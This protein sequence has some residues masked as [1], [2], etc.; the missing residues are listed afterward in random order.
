MVG[1]V[2]RRV[3][4]AILRGERVGLRADQESGEKNRANGFRYPP[5]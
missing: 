2:G 4:D 3:V 1:T 5:V